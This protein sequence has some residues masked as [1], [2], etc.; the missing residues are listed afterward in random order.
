MLGYYG[1]GISN[2]DGD[3]GDVNGNGIGNNRDGDNGDDNGDGTTSG[4]GLKVTGE[5]DRGELRPVAC[6]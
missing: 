5:G 6:W 4:G 1:L 3:N 2:G